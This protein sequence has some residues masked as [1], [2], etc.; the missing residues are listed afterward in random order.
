MDPLEEQYSNFRC[1]VCESKDFLINIF[2]NEAHQIAEKLCYCASVQ[3]SENDGLPQHICTH[4]LVDLQTAYD[5]RKRC[6]DTDAKLRSNSS[7]AIKVELFESVITPKAETNAEILESADYFNDIDSCMT[8]DTK[9]NTFDMCDLDVTEETAYIKSDS[10]D[11][12]TDT[13]ISFEHNG[14]SRAPKVY[15]C[16]TC[17]Q[18]FEM[19]IQYFE[20][21]KT[22]GAKR[23]QCR[24]C[25]KWFSR[26]TVW[27]QHESVH[28][29]TNKKLPCNKCEKCFNSR[30]ALLRHIAEIHEKI[31]KF[32]CNLCG[33]KFTQ[34]THLQAHEAVH[35]GLT[36]KCTQCEAMFKSHRSYL[37]HEQ[38]HLPPEERN[39]KLVAQ[40][41][42]KRYK[43]SK[44]WVCSFC[45]KVYNDQASHTIHQ[46]GHTGER[47]YQCKECDKAFFSSKNLSRHMRI[48]TGIRPYKCETCGKCFQEKSHL[49]THDLT[50]T[51]EKR[52][53]CQVCFKGFTL[54]C[55]LKSHMKCHSVCEK[56][57]S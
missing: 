17:D 38:M 36:Y 9:Q 44:T 42:P 25:S 29:G 24:T 10:D 31:Q 1:R 53:V 5:F 32:S 13:E 47:P 23:F 56:E 48:H 45:G 34:K 18:K 30:A 21:I 14:K 20:H 11:A 54:K 46:R 43:Y 22:H 28:E 4:C 19:R 6:E 55:S 12:E 2:V 3:V 37:R 52:F 35:A 41:Q 26:R 8:I 49:K 7:V 51:Q 39:P 50:H 15:T 33:R 57:S 40:K 16:H 27:E